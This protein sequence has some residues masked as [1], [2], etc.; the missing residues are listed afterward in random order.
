MYLQNE[1][2]RRKKELESAY[3]IISQGSAAAVRVQL[4][5]QIEE[6][7]SLNI[8]NEELLI[9]NERNSED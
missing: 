6:I 7:R 4:N 2:K 8:K 1:L 5:K 9:E 3:A